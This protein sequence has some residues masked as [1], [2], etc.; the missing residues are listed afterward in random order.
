MSCNGLHEEMR[1]SEGRLQDIGRSPKATIKRL[2]LVLEMAISEATAAKSPT[3]YGLL[4]E[5][6]KI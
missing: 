6:T 1:K 5:Y 4:E 3:R 2:H